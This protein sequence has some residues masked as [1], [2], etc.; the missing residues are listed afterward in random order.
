MKKKLLGLIICGAISLAACS[1]TEETTASTDKKSEENLTELTNVLDEKEGTITDLNQQI[2]DLKHQVEILTMENEIFP[3]ISSLTYNFVQAHT[4]G[5]KETLYQLIT[6]DV[7]IEEKGT[8]LYVNNHG[9]YTLISKDIQEDFLNW[10]LRNYTYNEENNTLVVYLTEFYEPES[11][12]DIGL[13]FKKTDDEYG[14]KIYNIE[15]D[16]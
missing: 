6:D 4:S 5:D 12:S 8:E 14:W 11:S 16:Q 15:F 10:T 3:H 9:E 1:Q 2:E 13:Y 7:M